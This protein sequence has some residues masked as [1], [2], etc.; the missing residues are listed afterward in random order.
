METLLKLIL[1]GSGIIIAIIIV[2][3]G[4]LLLN[5][6][7]FDS[8]PAGEPAMADKAWH[9]TVPTPEGDVLCITYRDNITC[10]WN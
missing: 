5:P 7:Y 10:D 4:T 6:G 2:I 9:R 3:M 1:G 8:S